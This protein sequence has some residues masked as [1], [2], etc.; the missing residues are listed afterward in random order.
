M[1]RRP[2]RSTLFPYTTL[3]RSLAQRSLTGVHG[4]VSGVRPGGEHT[5]DL[6]DAPA[7]D[8]GREG[9][10]NADGHGHR[11]L[12]ASTGAQEAGYSGG[13]QAL[14]RLHRTGALPVGAPGGRVVRTAPDETQG[15]GHYRDGFLRRRRKRGV[16]S[17]LP[18]NFEVGRPA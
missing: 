3:F 17:I 13:R 9:Y 18:G 11:G 5:L 6:A 2:P 15:G 16:R 8:R 14:R 12:R 10:S 7:D 1:I 4:G